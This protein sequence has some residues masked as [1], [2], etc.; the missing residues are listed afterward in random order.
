MEFVYI[1]KEIYFEELAH[2]IMEAAASKICSVGQ[3]AGDTGEPIVQIKSNL[4]AGEF[5]PA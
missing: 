4:A 5:P 1:W 3:Q 2:T